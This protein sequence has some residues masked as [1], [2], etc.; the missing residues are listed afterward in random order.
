LQHDDLRC[1]SV[2]APQ[3]MVFFAAR[4]DRSVVVS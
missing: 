1:K 2:A 3:N 4:E